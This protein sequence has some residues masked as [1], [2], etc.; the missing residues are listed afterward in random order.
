MKTK[1]EIRAKK[2]YP[3]YIALTHLYYK[4]A[5]SAFTIKIVKM[6]FL[7]DN[8]FFRNLFDEDVFQLTPKT[9][10]AEH[11]EFFV[12]DDATFF[13]Q[14]QIMSSNNQVEIG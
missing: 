6:R 11:F 13:F 7:D 3:S 2:V 12:F 8:I 14:F 10:L 1:V 9:N 5:F 4:I